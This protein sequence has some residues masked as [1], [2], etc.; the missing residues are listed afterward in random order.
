M[1][2]LNL[3]I[4]LMLLSIIT[5]AQWT[6]NTDVNTQVSTY[7]SENQD[8]KS[9]SLDAGRTAIV[10]WKEVTTGGNYELWLQILDADGNK[11]LGAEGSLI[12]NTIPM[13]TFVNSWTLTTDIN[14][15]IYIGVTGTDGAIGI[16]FKLDNNGAHL[17]PSE[18]VNLGSG[19]S[20]TI[21]PLS[22][23]NTII[24]WMS[25]STYKS[26][27]Q[28]FDTN[29]DAVWATNLLTDPNGYTVPASLFE[30]SNGDIVSI[31]HQ[32]TGSGVN[33]YLWAQRYTSNGDY[34][35]TNPIQISSKGT[36]YNTT[37]SPAQNAD[38]IYFGYVG[39]HDNRFDSYIQR[40][41][42]DGTLPWGVDGLDFDIRQTDYEMDTRIAIEDGSNYL[43]AICTYTNSSQ[44]LYGEAVQKFDMANGTRLLSDTAKVV[45][46]IGTEFTHNDKLKV[47]N[48]N[49]LF[50]LEKGDNNGV[51][52]TM[53]DLIKLDGN[54]NF[55]WSDSSKAIAS[56]P[57]TNKSQ[58][59]INTKY[60]NQIV[61]TFVERKSTDTNPKIYAQNYVDITT[62]INNIDNIVNNNIIFNNPVNDKL[63]ITSNNTI[64][65][66]KIIDVMGRTVYQQADLNIDNININTAN[67]N[68]GLY[69]LVI[70]SKETF[71]IIKE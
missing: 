49:P 4:V 7:E 17:W 39:K 24:S 63:I 69:V 27:I 2:T 12:S 16:A 50:V 46:A 43:W 19:Y 6:T 13:S 67:W 61:I 68:N 23:G 35:F 48:D 33:S 25:G 53:L 34:V 65:D 44:S 64:N 51:S 54:G 57:G 8:F 58:A 36:V 21:L 5:N 11:E 37:Y 40:I 20:L 62:G 45:Y 56:N 59:M 52:V 1:K 38:T 71:K 9:V 55:A 31:Y 70:N 14:N 10:F 28:K 47:Y 42:P 29:G 22:D 30:L 18:G 26:Y 60:N 15:N 3:L 32:L 41:N 66:I